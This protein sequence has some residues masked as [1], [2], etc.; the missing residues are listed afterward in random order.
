[1]A[2]C[3]FLHFNKAPIGRTAISTNEQTAFVIIDSELIRE[4]IIDVP[5]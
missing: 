4:F 2:I 3:L 1:M 5:V